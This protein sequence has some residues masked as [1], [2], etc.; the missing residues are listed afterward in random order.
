MSCVPVLIISIECDIGHVG[1]ILFC[2]GYYFGCYFVWAYWV[3]LNILVIFICLIG[4]ATN[5]YD[6][7]YELKPRDYTN[8]WA[9]NK[10][11][12]FQLR[13]LK[14]FSPVIVRLEKMGQVWKYGY[15]WILVD[16][17]RMNNLIQLGEL[18]QADNVAGVENLSNLLE[19][20]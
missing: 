1:F 3:W 19:L 10:L 18:T 2:H 9:L 13:L 5:I 6:F 14:S 4:F 12:H 11:I 7:F 8:T 15:L 17:F 16:R 20:Y